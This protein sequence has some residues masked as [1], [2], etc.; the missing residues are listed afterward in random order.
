MEQEGINALAELWE[1]T[2]TFR[3]TGEKML[4]VA[5]K[6]SHGNPAMKVFGWCLANLRRKKNLLSVVQVSFRQILM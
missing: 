1:E 4:W 6:L 3:K 2:G 5:L